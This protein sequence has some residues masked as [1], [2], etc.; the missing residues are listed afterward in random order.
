MQSS[1]STSVT[2]STDDLFER[3]SVAAPGLGQRSV[4]LSFLGAAMSIRPPRRTREVPSDGAGVPLA[5]YEAYPELAKALLLPVGA[6]LVA[7]LESIDPAA[8]DDGGQI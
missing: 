8:L 5:D 3:P 6:G 1:M 2:W 7:Q 4:W